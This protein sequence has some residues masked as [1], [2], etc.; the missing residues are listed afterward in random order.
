MYVKQAK[1]ILMNGILLLILKK[2]PYTT[3]RGGIV[4]R[5]SDLRNFKYNDEA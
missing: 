3:K 5:K 2:L 1:N 4:T